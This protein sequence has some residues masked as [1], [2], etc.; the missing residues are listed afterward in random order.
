MA[1]IV[2][3]K[4]TKRFG[5]VTAVNQLSVEIATVSSSACW[6]PGAGKTTTLRLI[7]GLEHPDE[8]DIIIDGE[9]AND[10][11]PGK[12]DIA[13]MF[14]NLA[15]YPD[16]TVFDNIAYPL[17]ERKMPK[18]QIQTRVTAVPRSCTST[19]CCSASRR[20]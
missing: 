1:N 9:R 10:V 12:R 17:R 19:T 6:A 20:N 3:E 13:M 15:L 11:H 8:G 14:Q 16:K 4:V 5:H 2:L 18:E 7:V